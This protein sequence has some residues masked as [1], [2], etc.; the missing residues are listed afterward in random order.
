KSTDGG[1]SWTPLTDGQA[2][3]AIGSLGISYDGQ[4]IYAGTGE[5][6]Q[7]TSQ[8]GQ[9]ILVSTN[10]GATW[11]LT[12]QSQLAGRHV[13]SIA[14]DS[15]NSLHALAATDAGLFVTIDGGTTWAENLQIRSQINYFLF[16]TPS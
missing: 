8:Y 14:V 2:S 12:A 13:A 11:T 6:N 16:R 5:D 7:S 4:T 15:S 3:L 9:G 1:T 10:G